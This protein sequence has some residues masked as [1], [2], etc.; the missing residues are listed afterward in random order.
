MVDTV[1]ITSEYNEGGKFWLTKNLQLLQIDKI[2]EPMTKLYIDA[3]INAETK[4]IRIFTHANFANYEEE[5]SSDEI[6][7]T[8]ELTCTT[9]T[10]RLIFRQNLAESNNHVPAF[11]QSVYEFEISLPMAAGFDLTYYQVS[12]S[13]ASLAS[14]I[15]VFR[16]NPAKCL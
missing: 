11:S 14:F 6:V 1:A 4:V 5:Q 9:G 7:L 16:F 10:R 12:A 2:N 8:L 13:F 15:V 3:E